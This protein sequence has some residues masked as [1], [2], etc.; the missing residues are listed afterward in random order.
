MVLRPVCDGDFAKS[1]KSY[2]ESYVLREISEQNEEKR[3]NAD[4]GLRRDNILAV[5]R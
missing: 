1:R 4:V 2:G 5:K 3:S